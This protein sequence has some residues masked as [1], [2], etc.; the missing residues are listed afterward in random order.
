VSQ[1]VP[2]WSG[3]PTAATHLVMLTRMCT[4]LSHL[5]SLPPITVLSFPDPE[6]STSQSSALSPSALDSRS[7][8]TSS[9][10]GEASLLMAHSP[11]TT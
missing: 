2:A 5:L 10:H 4:L 9:Q 6:S 7:Y 1:L 11:S 8:S 3:Y